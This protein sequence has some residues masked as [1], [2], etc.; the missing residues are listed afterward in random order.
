MRNA[1]C[2]ECTLTCKRWH[3]RRK[4]VMALLA[5]TDWAKM[6]KWPTVRRSIRG[7]IPYGVLDANGRLIGFARVVTDCATTFYLADVIIDESM[8]GKGLGIA[9]LRYILSDKRF[10]TRSGMLLT[11][12]AHG[13]YAKEGFKPYGE[14]FMMRDATN[15]T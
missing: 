6:R 12:T 15:R 2:G 14:R 4:E 7:S 1:R 3:F 9:M 8:R 10:N 11:R 5:Q 13:L